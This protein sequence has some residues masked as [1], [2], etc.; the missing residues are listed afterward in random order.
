MIMDAYKI[1]HGDGLII[2]GAVYKLTGVIYPNVV[3]N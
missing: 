1:P 2:P 3:H